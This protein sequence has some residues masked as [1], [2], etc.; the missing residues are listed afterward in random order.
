MAND[1]SSAAIAWRDFIRSG[2]SNLPVHSA[3][4][5]DRVTNAFKQPQQLPAERAY[6]NGFD[7]I[8]HGSAITMAMLHNTLTGA[9]QT[10][11]HGP[12]WM[13]GSA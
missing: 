5:I 2:S 12:S 1:A 8:G 7:M 6:F 3:G 11:L 10:V 4:I 13:R 9:P